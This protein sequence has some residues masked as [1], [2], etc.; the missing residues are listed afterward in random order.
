[1]VSNPT[2]RRLYVGQ[3]NGKVEVWDRRGGRGG[4]GGG[5]GGGGIHGQG[6]G[7]GHGLNPHGINPAYALYGG[8]G[9]GV[10][11][12]GGGSSGSSSSGSPLFELGGQDHSHA[13]AVYSIAVGDGGDGGVDEGAVPLVATAS[14]DRTA[15][16]WCG[17]TGRLVSAVGLYKLNAVDP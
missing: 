6:Y 15:R 16:V 14:V 4:G 17:D 12:G 8:G 11:G 1:V 7:H 5:G 3:R 2:D 9:G 10:S 13:G